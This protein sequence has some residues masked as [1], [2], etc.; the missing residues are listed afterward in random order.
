MFGPDDGDLNMDSQ[1]TADEL[2]KKRLAGSVLMA[3]NEI[4]RA[5]TIFKA[6]GDISML[7]TAQ[8]AEVINLC[9]VF[10]NFEITLC[11][12]EQVY[13]EQV[14]D[15]LSGNSLSARRSDGRLVGGVN[16]KFIIC[17]FNV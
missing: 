4:L 13:N 6:R 9:E 2:L 17:N 16:N 3:C 5:I 7:I 15:L 10:K 8:F 14:A 12:F 11:Y 1:V